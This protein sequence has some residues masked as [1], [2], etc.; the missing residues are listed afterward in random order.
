MF[1]SQVFLNLYFRLKI[2]FLFCAI[3]A[4]LLCF[5][6]VPSKHD[7]YLMKHKVSEGILSIIWIIWSLRKTGK[8]ALQITGLLKTDGKITL[9]DREKKHIDR[10]D[11]N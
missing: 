11:N 9:Y 1:E 10:F 6:S 7:F 8:L 5:S 3:K 2:M 4:W